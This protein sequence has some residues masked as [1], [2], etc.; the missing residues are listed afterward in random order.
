MSIDATFAASCL[1]LLLYIILFIAREI[2]TVSDHPWWST[3]AIVWGAT[4]YLLPL[5]SGLFPQSETTRILSEGE[6]FG[7]E[8]GRFFGG[9]LPITA[10]TWRVRINDLQKKR[11]IYREG[12]TGMITLRARHEHSTGGSPFEY[13]DQVER[14]G[15]LLPEDIRCII[16]ILAYDGIARPL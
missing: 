1:G 2:E 13:L 5:L 16:A 8:V 11:E 3:L 12:L 9:L 7:L 6:V 15:L 14:V 4:V 10:L